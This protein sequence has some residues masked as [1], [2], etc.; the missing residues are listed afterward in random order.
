VAYVVKWVAYQLRWLHDQAPQK[1]VVKSRRIGFS[2]VVAFECACRAAGVDLINGRNVKPVNQN[3]IS[4]SHAQAKELLARCARHLEALGKATPEGTLIDTPGQTIV[5]LR[6][7]AKLIAFS[8]NPRTIRG[9]EGDVTLDEFGNTANQDKVWAAAAPLAKP[10]LG[11]PTGYKIRVVGTPEG[12]GNRFY[13]ICEGNLSKRFSVHKVDVRQAVADGFPLMAQDE[14][15]NAVPATIDDLRDEIGDPDTFAQEYLCFPP[16][17]LVA[18]PRGHVP[19]E[20]LRVGECVLTHRGRWRPITAVM[21]RPYSGDLVKVLAWGNQE[22][23]ECTPEHPFLVYD[24]ATASRSWKRACDLTPGDCLVL[25]KLNASIPG[26]LS[27][28]MAQV[29]A[30]YICE[31]S[32]SGTAVSFALNGTKPDEIEHLKTLLAACG[33]DSKWYPSRS[34]GCLMVNSVALA[35][36][37]SAWCGHGALHK[38]IPFD[39]I[40]GHESVF[41]DAMI[42]GDGCVVVRERPGDNRSSKRYAFTTI[43]RGLA[44]DMQSLA[45]TLGRRAG[46]VARPGG[47]STIEGR[48]VRCQ[49][50]YCVQISVGFHL[51]NSRHKN[52]A[53]PTKLGIAYRVR[54]VTASP[55][56]GTVYNLSVKHD[57]SYVAE[58]RAV[59]N[60]SFLSASGR[61]ISEELW[62][63]CV[64]HPEDRPPVMAGT[65]AIYGGMD[66]ARKRHA[67][68]I[69]RVERAGE[70]LWHLDTESERNMKWADQEA[71][72]DRKIERCARMAVDATGLGSQFAE[73]LENRWYGRVEPIVF[74]APVK[75]DLATGFKLALERKRFRPLADDAVL[76]KSVLLLRR[77]VTE[78]GNVRFDAEEDKDGHGDEGWAAALAVHAAGGAAK[79]VAVP[80]VTTPANDN[81]AAVTASG[82]FAKKRGGGWR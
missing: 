66:I 43:S 7:G 5:K 26:L 20:R 77:K 36:T 18:T 72:V 65:T 70:T 55:Y 73:R 41:F 25:P 47:E 39:L 51:P 6:N 49:R 42:S 54:S 52:Q 46:I 31:G 9:Y 11:T 14:A 79:K 58:G 78:A 23:V 37:L 2:E 44:L 82:P 40:R 33:F 75:E 10:N 32:V 34:S 15:G 17:T 64:Y 61:Y 80:K 81:S 67:S 22:P 69:V 8:S 53:F 76:R 50:S 13:R 74:T 45:G 30:W 71:W 1:A 62:D 38:R 59:H 35:D 63:A 21:S 57:E 68:A 48:T 19:I 60:C 27:P 3:I 28:E 24:K 29:I 4:A 56:S 12:D 16:G